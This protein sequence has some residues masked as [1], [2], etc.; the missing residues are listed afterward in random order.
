MKLAIQAAGASLIG[1]V[2][3]GLLLFLPAGTFDYWQAWVFIAAFAIATTVLTIYLLLTNPA[4]LQGRMA[5]GPAAG[6]QN[7]REFASPC[8]F[9]GNPTV[10]G[11]NAFYHS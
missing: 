2:L 11:F 5:A 9:L 10:M 8:L 1:L 4:V 7:A 3:F 6:T